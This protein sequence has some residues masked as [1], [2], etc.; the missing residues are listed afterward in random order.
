MCIQ[1]FY[2]LNDVKKILFE[3]SNSLNFTLNRKNEDNINN[4]NINHNFGKIYPSVITEESP[5][6][7]ELTPLLGTKRKNKLLDDC[8]SKGSIR[9]LNQINGIKRY[10][11]QICIL[12]WLNILITNKDE[13]LK[14]IEPEILEKN[15]KTFDNLLDLTLKEI[16]SNNICKKA[17]KG[18]ITLDHNKN[19]IQNIKKNCI[20][21]IKLNL[22]FRDVLRMFFNDFSIENEINVNNIREGLLDYIQ[23]FKSL[24]ANKKFHSVAFK[25][26]F[27]HNLNNLFIKVKNDIS[28]LEKSTGPTY[29]ECEDIFDTETNRLLFINIK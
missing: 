11:I 9:N 23:Y 1:D 8:D 20:L 10:L 22:K 7:K 25:R 16:Y 21:D 12:N 6:I 17:I 27:M 4:T 18:K 2:Q 3:S 5:I 29:E 15:Y 19:I 13:K 26:K 24:D 28:P 14:K